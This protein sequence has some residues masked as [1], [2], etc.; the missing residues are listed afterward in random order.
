[1]EGYMS[2]EVRIEKCFIDR[3]LRVICIETVIVAGDTN[4][5]KWPRTYLEELNC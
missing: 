5:I 3:N 4:E 2:L 1:M